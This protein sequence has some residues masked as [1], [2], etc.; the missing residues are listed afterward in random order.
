MQLDSGSKRSA[1][2]CVPIRE[3]PLNCKTAKSV[4]D[5]AGSLP[6]SPKARG[7]LA[8]S[9]SARCFTSLSEAVERAAVAR[10]SFPRTGQVNT[11]GGIPSLLSTRSLET[12]E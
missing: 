6:H 12:G 1:L 7:E 8:A 3:S 2:V 10:F 5:A 4:R 9:S 11:K